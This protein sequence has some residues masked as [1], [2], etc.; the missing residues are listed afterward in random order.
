MQTGF[1]GL[2]VLGL[3]HLSWLMVTKTTLI[4]RIESHTSRNRMQYE[5]MC[6][7]LNNIPAQPTK[8][9]LHDEWLRTR[10]WKI[11]SA[12]WSVYIIEWRN[13]LVCA[14]DIPIQSMIRSQKRK[15]GVLQKTRQNGH[16]LGDFMPE[17]LIKCKHWLVF[18]IP[19]WN[20]QS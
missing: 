1:H 6:S 16:Y 13:L 14:C 9:R 10:S 20:I 5:K 2:W 7:E 18:I 4:C 19:Q 15:G 8:H 12:G 17:C 11:L 3:V